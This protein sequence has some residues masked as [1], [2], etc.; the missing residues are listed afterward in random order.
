MP[1]KKESSLVNLLVNIVIPSLILIKL[2]KPEFLG[3]MAGFVIALA[4]PF[5][6][7]IWG[8]VKTKKPNFFSIIGIFSIALTGGIGLL[9]LP[10]EWIAVKEALIPLIIGIGILISQKTKYPFVKGIIHKI[11]DTDKVH[12]ALEIHNTR[13][14][15]KKNLSLIGYLF[16]GSFFLSAFLNYFLAKFIVVSAPGTTEFNAE[17]GKMT[18]LSYPVIAVPLTVLMTIIVMYLLFKTKK[19]TKLEIEHIIKQ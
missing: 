18:A 6:Y 1:Q 4:I 12:P 3:Q 7:G 15:Y 8:F 5:L 2:S 10:P 17:I 11:I 13:A 16:S 14:E 19:L 9:K